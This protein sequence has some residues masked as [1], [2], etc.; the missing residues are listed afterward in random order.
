MDQFIRML[1][2]WKE[3]LRVKLMDTKKDKRTAGKKEKKNCTLH[4]GEGHWG[5]K[6]F[7]NIFIIGMHSVIKFNYKV[8]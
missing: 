6:N 5:K 8:I 1:F 7:V 3:G 2:P 4:G